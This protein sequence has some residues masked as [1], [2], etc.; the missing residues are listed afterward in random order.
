MTSSRNYRGK[1][2]EERKEARR[3][4]LLHAA[5][6]QFGEVGYRAT[7]VQAI[8]DA[9]GLT[10]R[11]FYESYK[12]SNHLLEECFRV[13]VGELI[14][15]LSDYAAGQAALAPRARARAILTR[16]FEALR[17]D[18]GQSRLFL[19]DAEGVSA[20]VTAAMHDA[21]RAMADLLVP[22]DLFGFGDASA[23]LYRLG[24]MSGLARISSLWIAGNCVLPVAEVVESGL[25]LF[26]SALQ[27]AAGSS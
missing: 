8:C 6:S 11:Y 2:P 13:S 17:D 14:E 3:L 5:I 10:K 20:G 23:S 15:E 19:L 1:S 22:A 25:R 7:T 21:E 16:Y 24:A 12:D 4:R 27:P 9:A 18:P 26:D